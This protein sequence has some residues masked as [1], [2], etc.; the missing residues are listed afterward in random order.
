MCSKH[1]QRWKRNGST[2]LL[3]EY[4]GP[5]KDYPEEYKSWEAMRD[6]CLNSNNVYFHRYGG[7]GIKICDRWQGVHGFANFIEDMGAKPS[8]ERTSKNW[9][10]YTL[11][12]IDRDGDYCP[13]NCR[14]AT[15]L[16]QSGNRCTSSETPGVNFV[17]LDNKWKA[18]YRANGKNLCRTFATKEE[19]I[20]QRKQWETEIPLN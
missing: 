2:E 7:R 11:D 4:N 6:R 16:I 12:R 13:E 3:I 20:A 18:R 15:W 10:K 1:Y 17:K 14:W 5:R 9:P 8:Y 19:A